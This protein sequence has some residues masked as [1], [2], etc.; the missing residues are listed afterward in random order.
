MPCSCI[1]KIN[2]KLAASKETSNTTLDLTFDIPMKG[3]TAYE[4][5]IIATKKRDPHDKRKPV[6]L[7]PAYC[8][9]CGEKLE[10]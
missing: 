8:P 4:R 1:K 10:R 7:V 3:G 6:T 5:M 2:R 9:L